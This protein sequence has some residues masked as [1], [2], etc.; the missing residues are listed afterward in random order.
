MSVVDVTKMWSRDSASTSSPRAEPVGFDFNFTTAYQVLVNDPDDTQVTVLLAND[1]PKI[2]D[3]F[4]EPGVDAYCVG[5]SVSRIGPVF[6]QVEVQYLG[7]PIDASV[8]VQWGDTSTTE[9]IDEDW[10]GR[11]IVNANG[12]PVAGLTMDIADQTCTISRQFFYINTFAI[13]EY[14]H[15]T[16]SDSF[17][18]WPPGTCRLTGYS[19]K[20]RFKYGAPQELWQVSATFQF[21]YP[22]RVTA[23]KAWYKRY[24]N[25]GLY[26]L[27]DGVIVRAT[28]G[29][30]TEESK[31]VLLKSNGER[32]YDPDAAV[33]L[34]AQ[35][36]GSLPF[37]SL[38]LL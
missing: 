19:A 32:E 17:L 27:K 34:T 6:W 36:Y 1:L 30:G 21:R 28:D 38:G 15:A 25:E 37:N 35:V 20:N 13:Y 12:E 4:P 23:D 18:G 33:W 31:P 22:Y 24:R 10:N 9:E 26:E 8:D 16:N 5:H 29:I 11:A 3:Q 14:R 2:G 7:F